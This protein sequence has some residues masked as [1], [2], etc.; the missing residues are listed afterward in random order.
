M[1]FPSC[2]TSQLELQV[3][4]YYLK[5]RLCFSKSG[6]NILKPSILAIFANSEK[7]NKPMTAGN[8][9]KDNTDN[10]NQL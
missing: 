4:G 1:S 9:L 5:T 10:G 2:H 7:E 6:L 3:H 8:R